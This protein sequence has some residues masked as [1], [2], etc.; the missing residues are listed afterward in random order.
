LKRDRFAGRLATASRKCAGDR[1]LVEAKDFKLNVSPACSAPQAECHV[2]AAA[3]DIE[4]AESIAG[5]GVKFAFDAAPQLASDGGRS[6]EAAQSSEGLPM[7]AQ[8]EAGAIH[9]L[10]NQAALA[11]DGRHRVRKS[12]FGSRKSVRLG[13]KR[14]AEGSEAP[15]APA[16]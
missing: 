4:Q 13:C 8:I 16:I 11:R 12:S 14:C 15:I 7:K 9:L 10:G 1:A 6:V 5:P 2:A 3:G